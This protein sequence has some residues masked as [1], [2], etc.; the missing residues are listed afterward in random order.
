MSW[1]WDCGGDVGGGMSLR[2]QPLRRTLKTPHAKSLCSSPRSP[3]IPCLL[4]HAYSSSGGVGM[5][6]L[7]MSITSDRPFQSTMATGGELTRTLTLKCMGARRSHVTPAAR[8][9]HLPP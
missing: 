9:H 2:W 3:R 1:G 5:D 8:H 6:P 7:A 4:T